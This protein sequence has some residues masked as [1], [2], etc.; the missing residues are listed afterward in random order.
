MNNIYIKSTVELLYLALM[1]RWERTASPDGHKGNLDGKEVINSQTA[2]LAYILI[3][4]AA[5]NE[6]RDYQKLAQH[7]RRRDGHSRVSKND[8]SMIS[9]YTLTNGWY[10]EGCAN[11]SKEKL[12]C[13]HALTYLGLSARFVDAVEDFVSGKSIISYYPTI[14]Q[15]KEILRNLGGSDGV[16]SCVKS[17]PT[18]IQASIRDFAEK[19]TNQLGLA[20]AK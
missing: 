4:I 10:L 8:A 13:I 16:D 2:R 1:I 19:L 17:L 9:P 12:E 5:G 18:E 11:L 15:L 20:V 14:E 6:E 7:T 3:K